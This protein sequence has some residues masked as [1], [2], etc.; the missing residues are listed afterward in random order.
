MGNYSPSAY[1]P[2][3]TLQL[4]YNKGDKLETLV[5]LTQNLP[6][7]KANEDFEK[8]YRQAI[9]NHQRFDPTDRGAIWISNRFTQYLQQQKGNNILHTAIW[10]IGIFTLLS[11]NEGVSNIKLI[12]VKEP[13]R[14]YGIRKA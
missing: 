4:I 6:T 2:L 7:E 10:V 9:G 5:F 11:G 3:T 1:I 12:T 14:E 13:T 8:Q